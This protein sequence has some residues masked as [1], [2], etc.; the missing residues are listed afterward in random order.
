M[1]ESIE[2]SYLHSLAFSLSLS[3]S[4]SLTHTLFLWDKY[5]PLYIKIPIEKK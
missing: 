1:T 5:S 3:L 4:L 2:S